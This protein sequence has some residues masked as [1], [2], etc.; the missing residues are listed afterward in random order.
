MNIALKLFKYLGFFLGGVAGF[1]LLLLVAGNF[2]LQT[3]FFTGFVLD[4]VLPGVGQSLGADLQVKSLRVSLVPTS[5]LIE[6]AH[7]TPAQGDFKRKFVSLDRLYLDVATTKLLSG[8]LVVEKLELQGVSSYL[9]FKDGLANLPSSGKPPKPKE[10]KEPSGPLE[11]KY[12]VVIEAFRL[13]DSSLYIDMPDSNLELGIRNIFLGLAGSLENGTAALEIAMKDGYFGMGEIND[14]LESLDIKGTTDLHEWT[15]VIQTLAIR[16]P[17]LQLDADATAEQLIGELAAKINLKLNLD[18]SKAALFVKNPDIA[19]NVGLDAVVDFGLPKTGMTY[20]VN[21]HLALN[22]MRLNQ[23]P[24]HLSTD[25]YADTEVAEVKGLSG[26]VGTGSLNLWAKL[27]LTGQKPLDAKI[28]LSG[29]DIGKAATGYGVKVPMDGVLDADLAAT[30]HLAQAT[31]QK[32]KDGNPKGRM[33]L[34]TKGDL[35]VS[36]FAMGQGA[37]RIVAIP[38]IGVNLDANYVGTVAKIHKTTIKTAKSLIEAKGSYDTKGP[39]DITLDLAL[40]D[41]KEFSPII[42]KSIAGKGK[43][44]AVAK[45]TAKNP[46]VT[47]QLAF[48]D[49][50]FDAFAVDEISGTVGLDGKNATLNSLTIRAGE[51]RIK[52]TGEAFLGK[53][54]KVKANLKIP[55]G[56]LE[57]FATLAGKK[58]LDLGGKINLDL[59]IDGPVDQI[60]GKVVLNLNEIRAFGEVVKIVTLNTHMESGLIVLDDLRIEKLVPPRIDLSARKDKQIQEVPKDQW[61]PAVIAAK[62]KFDPASGEVELK[63]RTQNLNEQVSD[64]IRKKHLPLQAEFSIQADVTGTLKDPDVKAKIEVEKARYGEYILGDTIITATVLD[65]QAKIH[66]ALLANR[67]VEKTLPAMEGWVIVRRTEPRPPPSAD[68][69]GEVAEDFTQAVDTETV[70]E[71]AGQFGTIKLDLDAAIDGEQPVKGALVFDQFDFSGFLGSLRDKESGKRKKTGKKSILQGRLNGKVD[72]NGSLKKAADM[73]IQANLDELYFQKNDFVLN[74][75]DA[76]GKTQPI[77]ATVRGKTIQLDN[78]HL[79]GSAVNLTVEDAQVLGRD[80]LLLKGEIKLDAAKEF[81]S[82]LSESRGT[83]LI[84]ATIPKDFKLTDAAARIDLLDGS[85]DVQNSPTSLEKLNLLVNFENGVASIDK[86]TGNIGGGTL[87]GD[88][89]VVLDLSG[90]KEPKPPDINLV[91]KLRDIK[92]GFDPYLEAGVQKVDLIISDRPAGG[93]D[94]T[95][96][97]VIDKAVY[98]KNIDF[99]SIL[100]SFQQPKKVAGKATFEQKKENLFFNVAIRAD[101]QVAFQN[102]F[103]DIEVKTDLLFTGSNVTPALLGNVEVI[104]GKAEVLENDYKVTRGVITFLDED[105]IYPNFDINVETQVKDTQVY[106]IVSGKPDRYKLTFTSDPPMPERDIFTLLTFGVSYEEFQADTSGSTDDAAAIAAQQV[107]GSQLKGLTGDS[108]FDINVDSAAGEPRLKV[109]TEVEKDFYLSIY[110]GISSPSLGAEIEY[111][112]IRNLGLMGN[113]DNLAGYEDAESIGAFG[114]GLKI[115]LEFR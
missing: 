82:L 16:M 102:N 61:M 77:R 64:T 86:L 76:S 22:Q 63:L 32:D 12:P 48:D 94:V 65:K 8:R 91:V 38:K 45:G 9:L 5:V 54:M 35:G 109:K 52:A 106:V 79:G 104:K 69:K 2:L 13:E 25:L 46:K 62:G 71:T 24:I 14:T 42:G 40:D 21:G 80:G 90:A 81:T 7:F 30:G 20:A 33:A 88:G 11:L 100:I 29:L 87:T 73:L 51:S 60:T 108:G 78:L 17:G 92:T 107:I 83:L 19:G 89:K 55:V 27:G 47:S 72:V 58:D 59:D 15:A 3:E 97:V 66:G 105:R 39:M 111:D 67:W 28:T 68:E 1:V 101:E 43:L 99:L 93:L 113:W 85:F 18:A 56:K 53:P 75:I 44:K 34:H 96:E 50:Q 26:N 49:L 36:K 31:G 112:F 4:R 74:N 10:P 37:K 23:L 95:G 98:S 41:L 6:G 84:M 103:T 70:V 110:R 57:D 115:K 114:T